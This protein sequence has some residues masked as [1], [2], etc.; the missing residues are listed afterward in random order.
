MSKILVDGRILNFSSFLRVG[1]EG[2]RRIGL[3]TLIV[4]AFDIISLSF[5]LS[6]TRRAATFFPPS[7]TIATPGDTIL[8][9]DTSSM[10]VFFPLRKAFNAILFETGHVETLHFGFIRS[11]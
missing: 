2:F 8:M 3:K 9:I 10:G 1:G 7:L 5:G 4:F 11:I 6:V